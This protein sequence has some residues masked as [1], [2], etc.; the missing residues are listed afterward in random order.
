MAVIAGFTTTA[1]AAIVS[2]L[3]SVAEGRCSDDAASSIASCRSKR[4]RRVRNSPL[5]P[6]LKVD[7]RPPLHRH[8]APSKAVIP[9]GHWED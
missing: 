8:W 5:R 4:G 1:I 2:E 9:P 6:C 7:A 3:L